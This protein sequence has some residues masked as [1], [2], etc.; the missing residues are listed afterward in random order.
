M[1]RSDDRESLKQLMRDAPASFN[2]LLLQELLLISAQKKNMSF[3]EVVLDTMTSSHGGQVK[4]DTYALNAVLVALLEQGTHADAMRFYERM[5]AWDKL[6]T[7]TYY[8]LLKGANADAART[9]VR[10]MR[11]KHVT[12]SSEC[13]NYYLAALRNA[14]ED[15]E[16]LRVF[17]E[18][19][20][21]GPPPNMRTYL[22]FMGMSSRREEERREESRRVEE[23]RDTH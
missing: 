21:S 14:K 17:E 15:A 22:I 5:K 10:E 11:E 7:V 13:Y 12:V 18:M 8:L 3:V 4:P 20:E 16:M 19:K 1:I 6:N 23:R 2:A 9:L